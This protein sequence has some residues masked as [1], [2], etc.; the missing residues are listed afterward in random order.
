MMEREHGVELSFETS[1]REASL[2]L[3]VDG[4][5]LAAEVGALAHASDLLPRLDELLA[6]AGRPRGPGRLALAA[7]HVG[8]GPGSYTG[9]RVGIATALGLARASGAELFGL[10]SFEALA[11]AALAPGE[12]AAVVLD[13][14]AGRFYHAH[15]RRTADDVTVA[16]APVA[17]TADE[18]VARCADAPR[19]LAHPGLSG[20]AGLPDERVR[21]DLRPTA[22]AV[23]GLA[24]ARR[25]AG[26]LAPQ[27]TLEPLYLMS[28]GKSAGGPPHAG[29]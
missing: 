13:A 7:L 1:R 2:A 3:R 12:E 22:E 26:R 27:T 25:A 24:R 15:Y 14:R 18:L 11:W 28:F 16:S 8:L 5:V 29:R 17:C 23:L 4:R 9:L 21:T 20:A 6:R 19:I 10:C